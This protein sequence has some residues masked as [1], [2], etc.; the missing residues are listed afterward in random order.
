[1]AQRLDQGW[2]GTEHVLLALFDE[3]SAATGALGE[4][5]VTRDLAEKAAR[6]MGQ[7]DPPPSR[8]DPA[9]GLTPN[10]AWYQLTG[11]ATGLALA[12]GRR[13]PGPEH[14]LLAMV[15]GEHTV[16]ELLYEVGASERA[17]L[18]ALA[19]R[20]PGPPPPARVL[21]AV[22]APR[23]ATSTVSSIASSTAPS[24]GVAASS[25][26]RR[27]RA[28]RASTRVRA[29]QGTPNGASSRWKAT[30]RQPP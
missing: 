8:Y 11:C 24:A 19:R 27:R 16:P 2:I 10:P 12:V 30:P 20:G 13:R 5:G 29:S 7:A 1:M 22:Q 9:K 3:P 25:S 23:V 4:V 21:A 17:L 14:F 18:D 15:Y 26:S 6:A 28:A